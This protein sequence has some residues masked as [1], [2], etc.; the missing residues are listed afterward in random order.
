MAVSPAKQYMKRVIKFRGKTI[1]SGEWVY[2]DLGQS[3]DGY[4]RIYPASDKV[5][6][7][8]AVVPET[9]GQFT[10]LFDKNGAELWEG[11]I[12]SIKEHDTAT[13]HGGRVTLA[14]SPDAAGIECNSNYI[15]GS[16]EAHTGSKYEGYAVGPW[17]WGTKLLGNIHDNPELMKQ[18]KVYK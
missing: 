5:Q 12:V 10:G 14:L 9:V 2:G 18:F 15:S 13:E 1:E 3:T 11:D 6:P 4:C 16:W 8:F 7:G 17:K